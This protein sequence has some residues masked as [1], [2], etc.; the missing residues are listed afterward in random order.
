MV[1]CSSKHRV[2]L[3]LPSISAGSDLLFLLITGSKQ[4]KKSSEKNPPADGSFGLIGQNQVTYPL[5]KRSQE[6]RSGIAMLGV[7]ANNASFSQA[8]GRAPSSLNMLPCFKKLQPKEE[9]EKT[10][11]VFAPRLTVD[12]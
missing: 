12:L 11:A 3:Q 7:T 10:L 4:T 8:G 1:C 2:L 6:K 9:D 5:P